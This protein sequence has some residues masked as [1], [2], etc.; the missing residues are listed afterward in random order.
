MAFDANPNSTVLSVSWYAQSLL[1]HYRGTQTL[2]VTNT[3]GD[4]NPLFWV[5]SI[6]EPSNAIYLKVK[7]R[8]L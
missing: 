2:P 5:A 4:L 6:D 7:H 3:M 8:V 1:A